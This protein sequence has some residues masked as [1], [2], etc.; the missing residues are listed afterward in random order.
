MVMMV[1][2]IDMVRD[3]IKHF[4]QKKVTLPQGRHKIII[5]DEADRYDTSYIVAGNEKKLMHCMYLV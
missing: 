5:L 4:A 3:R 1:S 2:G